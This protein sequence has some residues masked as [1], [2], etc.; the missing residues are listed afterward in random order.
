MVLQ[1]E[2]TAPPVSRAHAERRAIRMRPAAALRAALSWIAVLALWELAGRTILAGRHLVGTPSG[3]VAKI[4]ENA[5][6]YGR[7]LMFTTGEAL[8]G[9]LIGNLAAVALALVVVLLPGLERIV[10]RLALVVYCLPLVALGPLLRLVY[11]FGDGPQITLAALA[12]YY[13]T[14]VPLL[15]GLRAVPRSWIDLTASY[16][17]GRWTTLVVV[18]ARA[19]LPYLMAGLQASVPAAFLGA[20]V[21]EFTGAERGLGVLSILALRSLDTDGLWALM[22]LSAAVSLVGYGVVSALARRLTPERPTV[23]LSPPASGR[24]RSA[25]LRWLRAVG[26]ATLVAVLVI[27]LWIVL[28]EL[29]GLDPYFAKRPWDVWEWLVTADAAS[30][31]RA[32]LLAALGQT[33]AVAIPGY[34]AGLLMGLLLATAFSLSNRVR[35]ALTPVAVALRCV[36]IIAI[37]PLLVAALGRGPFG[38]AVV[39]AIMTFFPTLVSCLYGL[40][41]LPGQVADVFATYATPAPRVLLLGRLPAMAPAFFAAARIA[42]PTALLAA[43]VAEWLATGTGLGNQMA[44][45]AA[46]SQYTSLW[47]TVVIVTVVSLAAYA[48]VEWIEARVLAR[49]APEQ[50]R[51]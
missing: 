45:D 24:R 41:Q 16:G 4:V 28:F 47:S 8:L 50:G 23:L 15:V 44:V 36:P 25:G 14:L 34:F 13:L 37:A 46:T 49:V 6:V 27:A 38:T 11:G 9:Y 22:L 10:L 39:V 33:V 7:G 12:V 5:E 51:W 31:H 17:R 1:A 20:L 43:T 35:R 18:R 30:E 2:P 26:G 21:G 48:L 19:A 3:I 42:A 40:R 32:E 29:L